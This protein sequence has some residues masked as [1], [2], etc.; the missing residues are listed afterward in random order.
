[1]SCAIINI[2]ASQFIISDKIVN[3]MISQLGSWLGSW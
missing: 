1:M 2:T 3:N